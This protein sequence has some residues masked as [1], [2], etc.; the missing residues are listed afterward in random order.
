MMSIRRFHSRALLIVALFA[1]ARAGEK[2]PHFSLVI[3]WLTGDQT[4]PL[5]PA[6]GAGPLKGWMAPENGEVGISTAMVPATAKD[7]QTPNATC[8]AAA[9]DALNSLVD[10]EFFLWVRRTRGG[11]IC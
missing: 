2:R 9:C 8:D 5:L 3:C 11:A 1:F 7:V 10:S 6:I 4:D